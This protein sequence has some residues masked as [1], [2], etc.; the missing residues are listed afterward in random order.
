MVD[1][2]ELQDMIDSVDLLEYASQSYD[3]ENRNGN[4]W[5]CSC[6]LHVDKTPSLCINAEDNYFHCFSC[7]VGGDIISWMKVFEGLS[8]S[9]AVKKLSQ[10]T[11]IEL[12][13]YEK[14]ES[15]DYYKK[16]RSSLNK[17]HREKE[18]VYLKADSYNR[19]SKQIPVEWVEE[20]I[21]EDTLRRFNIRIDN[22]SNRIVYP[23]YDANFRYICPKGRTRFKDF[24]EMGINK[25]INYS[26]IG[27]ADFFVGMKEN[28]D[29]ILKTHKVIVFEGIKSVMKAY[30]WGY[31][32]CVSAET[33]TINDEQVKILIKM[34]I[35][36]VTI[37]FDSDVDVK[38]V[39]EATKMLRRFTKV[40]IIKDSSGLLGEKEAPVDKG[41]IVFEKLLDERIEL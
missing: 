23:V 41:R 33:S 6:P 38:K 21:S 39:I 31:D 2:G 3:F 20:G 34:G 36:D 26:K 14:C 25:Y 5:F 30:D 24:K 7:G 4:R 22:D 1:S 9:Q 40:Y 16:L 37:A 28:R 35:K 10:I 32:Y 15:V 13:D 12:K 11:G 19:Y 18:R 8:F 17:K 27:A 29:S